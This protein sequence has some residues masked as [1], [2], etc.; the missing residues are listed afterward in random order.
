VNNKIEI[1]VI[2]CFTTSRK[3]SDLKD[4]FSFVKCSFRA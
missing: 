2:Y 1:D 3:I 4:K